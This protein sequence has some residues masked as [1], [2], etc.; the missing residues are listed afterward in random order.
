MKTFLRLLQLSRPYHHY[1]PEYII[2]IFLYTIFSL[3]S[4]TL[5]MPLMDALFSTGQHTVVTQLP[6]F[7]LSV[8]YFK[9]I[10]YYY[11]T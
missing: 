6:A 2:Y 11:L 8:S 10:F 7:S 5:V 9:D 1:V 4:F 3:F